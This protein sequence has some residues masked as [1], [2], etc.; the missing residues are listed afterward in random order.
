MSIYIELTNR[1]NAGYLRA[2][3]S[4]GQAVVLH[5]LTIM[6]KDGDWIVRE[7]DDALNHILCVLDQYGA[8]YRFGA[9][10]DTRWLSGGWSAHFEFLQGSL[11][12]RTDFVSRP[13]RISP[14]RLAKIW[15][16]QDKREIPFVDIV[17]LAELKKT[18]RE[19]DYVI[20]GELSRRMTSDEDSIRY[21][22]SARDILDFYTKDPDSVVSILAER[23]IGKDALKDVPSLEAAL[24][25]ERRRLMHANENRLSKYV[26][27]AQTWSDNWKTVE[28]EIAGLSLLDAHKVIIEKAEGFLPKRLPEDSENA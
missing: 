27:A 3:L 8:H 18:N 17:D 19:R 4:S 28:K 26:S 7:N 5:R 10:L 12:I 22:R 25:A 20:I 6:S 23:G 13:P 24:D 16:E 1:F 9:P 15:I 11:R 2:I 21:S 14:Q